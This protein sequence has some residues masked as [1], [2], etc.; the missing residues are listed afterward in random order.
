MVDKN[1][2]EFNILRDLLHEIRTDQKEI[3]GMINE[4][5]RKVAE[6]KQS[7]ENYK[8]AI[9]WLLTLWGILQGAFT[10]LLSMLFQ[11]HQP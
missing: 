2:E 3:Y 9:P 1:T 10:W 4:D 5:R 6:L 7:E 8:A 11:R